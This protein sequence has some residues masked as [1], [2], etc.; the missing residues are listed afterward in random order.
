[1][2][3]PYDDYLIHQRFGTVDEIESDDERWMERFWFGVC[4]PD[5][6]VGLICGLGTYPNTDMVDALALVVEP[7]R[8]HNLR[9]WRKLSPSRWTLDA[10]PLAFKIEAPM[11]KWHLSAS[12]S[13]VGIAFDLTFTARSQP[14]EMTPL[15]IHKDDR[16][17]IA[18]RHFVQSG[19]YDGWIEADGKRY[20]VDGWLG[21]RDRSWG[22]RSASGKVNRG[23]HIWLPIQ[24]PDNAPWAWI[25]E[26]PNGRRTGFS[27]ALRSGMEEPD[28][29]E[30]FSYELDLKQVGTH[31][32]LQKASLDLEAESGARK[33]IEAELLLPVFLSGGGYAD[34]E[35]GQGGTKADAGHDGEVWST[36]SE[37]DIAAI[38]PCIIDHFVRVEEDGKVGT[39]CF[40]LSI[41]VFEPLGFE[42]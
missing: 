32:I 9:S 29:L 18:Y 13:D 31:R 4:S 10:E 20:E 5:G 2:L 22:A 36:A 42:D 7:G 14:Y 30:D 37:E 34:D 12:R 3:G 24:L 23:L 39:A 17:V 41:G 25:S 35:T 15:L 16:L 26:R 27:G 40:E 19:R 1:M 21:E 38:P 28:P 8:Q 11:E 6:E 33:R